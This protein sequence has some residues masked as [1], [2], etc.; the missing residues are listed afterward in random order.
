MEIYHGGYCSIELPEIIKGKY[1][2]DFGSGFY[3]TEMKEQAMRWAKRYN[4][5]IVSIYEF[6][7]ND[8]LRILHFTEMTEEWL[9][10]IVDCRNGV[11]HNYDI[12]IGAMANDQIYNYISDYVSG[13]ITREQFWVLAKFKHP[14]HQI[15][16][17]TPAALKCLT[18]KRSEEVGK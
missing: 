1:A 5:P 10:F 11:P 9:D 18:F 13:V 8:L 3:C 16:F 2:K 17:C 15:N 12:V 4:T 6:E 14:T 7:A